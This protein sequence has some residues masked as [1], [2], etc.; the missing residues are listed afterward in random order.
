MSSMRI[1]TTPMCDRIL[2]LAGITDYIVS[3]N[4]DKING[5]IVVTL[6]ETLTSSKSLKIKL[7]TFSQIDESIKELSEI[8][9][10]TPLKYKMN[11][12]EYSKN[13]NEK[14]K[15]KVYSNFL[16][17]IVEDMGF[18][19]V[20]E[21]F[22]YIVYP[23]YMKDKILG[24]IKDNVRAVEV[25]SHKNVPLDPIKRAEMRYNILEKSLCTKH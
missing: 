11:K 4:P 3:S 22:D 14:I 16:R 23:D 18:T 20:Q 7:N 1:V 24:E 25:P 12:V 5:D 15:I 9:K 10:T 6:S 13:N 21:N 8:F 19:I 2:K 17:E